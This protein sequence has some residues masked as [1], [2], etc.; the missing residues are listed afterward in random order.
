M[1]SH[2]LPRQAKFAVEATFIEEIDYSV[3]GTEIYVIEPDVSALDQQNIESENNRP[4]RTFVHDMIRSLKS[5]SEVPLGLYM[6]AAGATAVEG[7]QAVA[8]PQSD[9]FKAC[10]GGR[11]LGWSIGFWRSDLCL[12]RQHRNR[13]VLHHRGHRG[14]RAHARP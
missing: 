2:A 3:A 13:R 10:L 6:T 8:T 9:I 7:A 14:D 11:N 4:R 1:P 5:G 12:R